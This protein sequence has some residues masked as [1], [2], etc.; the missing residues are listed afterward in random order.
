M[1]SSSTEHLSACTEGNSIT[2]A[3]QLIHKSM[4]VKYS[5]KLGP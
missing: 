3:S 2:T 5:P 1:K 4:N